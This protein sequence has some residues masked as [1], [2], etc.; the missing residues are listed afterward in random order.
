MIIITPTLGEKQGNKNL[1]NL[2]RITLL[3]GRPLGY[4]A[5][6]LASEFLGA[7]NHC[8]IPPLGHHQGGQLGLILV[9]APHARYYT[10]FPLVK[11][12]LQK[13]K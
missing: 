9:T 10:H 4:E 6:C 3:V 7:F 8:S 12:S 13:V 1:N 5:D 11:W 2:L